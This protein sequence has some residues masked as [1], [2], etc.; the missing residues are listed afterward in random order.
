M[1]VGMS[2][3]ESLHEILDLVAEQM[4][5]D[6][7]QSARIEHRGSKGTVRESDT[8]GTFFDKYLPGFAHVTG[9]GEL[10]SASGDFSGQC[11]LMIVD[12]DTPPLWAREDYA[13][14]PVECCY[15][16]VEVKSNLT[17]DELR[18]AWEASK[19]VKSLPRTS[20]LPEPSPISMKRRAYGREWQHAFPVRYI[21]FGYEGATLDSLA[22]EMS[23][24]AQRDA[25]PWVGID[26]VCVLNRGYV[27][28]QNIS[29]GGFF[30]RQKDSMA[31]TS[32]A[33]P[34]NVLLFMLTS[35]NEVL[36]RARYNE[37]FDI[38]GYIA[39]SFGQV[40]NWWRGG[41]EYGATPV[42]NGQIAVQPKRRP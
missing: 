37:K 23:V 3:A 16:V 36:A 42:G 2:T 17:V 24:L 40:E 4:R 30:E 22:R 33:T 26:A 8:R 39:Q 32:P 20:Y 25:E 1:M 9:S 10:V 21:V 6:F 15:V 14:V 28:W 5:L 12:A 18:K 35:L 41:V 29:T 27:S 7:E 31:F 34:G 13:I 11:D 19:K 38:K